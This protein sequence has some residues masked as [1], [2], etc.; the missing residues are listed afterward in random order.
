MDKPAYDYFMDIYLPS[1]ATWRI[2]YFASLYYMFMDVAIISIIWFG[3]M[4][5]F[6]VF[7]LFWLPIYISDILSLI[8]LSIAAILE[9][10][11]A[12]RFLKDVELFS[13]FCLI[14]NKNK[15]AELIAQA[16]ETDALARMQDALS[17]HLRL[18]HPFPKRS[19]GRKGANPA[20]KI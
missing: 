20:K 12:R 5:G 19:R 4:L 8:V 2:H 3:V 1:G 6:F 18:G 14:A 10:L 9:M 13:L 16:Q 11:S 15:L 17:F 7:N